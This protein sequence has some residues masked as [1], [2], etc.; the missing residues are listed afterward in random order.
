M[1]LYIIPVHITCSL[2]FFWLSP[3]TDLVTSR[4]SRGGDKGETAKIIKDEFEHVS[5]S[6]CSKCMPDSFFF[7]KS[8]EDMVSFLFCATPIGT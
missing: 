8:I 4:K 6:S 5:R 2:T 3:N 1:C 7:A